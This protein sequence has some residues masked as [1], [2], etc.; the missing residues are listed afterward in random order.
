MPDR[1]VELNLE[2]V[3]S[4]TW[5]GD[6]RRLRQIATELLSNA[7]R[8]TPDGG[9]IRMGACLD[10]RD[11][12]FEVVDNGVGIPKDQIPVIF[13]PFRTLVPISEHHS[14][15]SAHGGGG[16]GVG[17]SIVRDL[18]ERMGGT[19]GVVSDV[20]Q[21]CM[22]EIRLRENAAERESKATELKA[23]KR[24]EGAPPDGEERRDPGCDSSACDDPLDEIIRL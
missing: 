7:V 4:F 13:Q 17:L 2:G 3:S 14:S 10:E 8:A 18:V 1:R 19:I 20:G 24:T 5:R 11:L 21:G 9:S 12:I 15:E 6:G 16:L 23:G 22:V